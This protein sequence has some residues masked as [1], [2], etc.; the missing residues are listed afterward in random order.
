[1]FLLERGRS[2]VGDGVG[3]I[4]P[5]GNRSAELESL[6]IRRLRSPAQGG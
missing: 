2:G 4:F 5:D 1:M 3:V 6:E